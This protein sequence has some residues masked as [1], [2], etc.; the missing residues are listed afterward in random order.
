MLERRNNLLKGHVLSL[1][2]RLLAVLGDRH[3]DCGQRCQF[4]QEQKLAT[5]IDWKG[6]K[7]VALLLRHHFLMAGVDC[8]VGN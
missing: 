1:K 2:Y 5:A 6:Q 8:L 7:R 3:L 4:L